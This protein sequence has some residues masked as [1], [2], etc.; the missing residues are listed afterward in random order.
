M[1]P[2]EYFFYAE[3]TYLSF[4]AKFLGY[5]ILHNSNSFVEHFG[6]STTNN[7]KNSFVTYYQERNRILNFLIFFS[8]GFR[9]KYY[10]I[11][12]QNFYLKIIYG[13]FTKK[14]P[15]IGI[16]KAYYWILSNSKWIKEQRI[17][18]HQNKIKPE[19]DIF[20]FLSGKVA[21]GDNVFEKVLNFINL[22][23]LRLVN[24]KTI[25]LNKK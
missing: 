5:K 25:E 6:G 13:L 16:I 24:I 2:D 11:L 20:C 18:A 8:L 9:I 7:F 23:Y 4:K 19:N 1:F 17:I 12:L 21:N 3:D 22:T 10:P 14:Y 15:F